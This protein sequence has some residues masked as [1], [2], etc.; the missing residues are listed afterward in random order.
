LQL[1][2]NTTAAPATPDSLTRNAIERK[3]TPNNRLKTART[4]RNSKKTD[5]KLERTVENLTRRLKLKQ[6][7]ETS[8]SPN[9]TR[10]NG[11]K[12]KFNEQK[13]E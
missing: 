3:E 8:N 10:T 4:A 12:Q 7:V 1:H 13:L 2:H 9:K 5:R 6:T 11:G